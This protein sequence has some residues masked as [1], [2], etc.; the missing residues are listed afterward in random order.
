MAVKETTLS[1][2]SA[3]TA[4]AATTP[5]APAAKA[6]AIKMKDDVATFKSRPAV[7]PKEE[8]GLVAKAVDSAKD[9]AGEAKEF[10][11]DAVCELS[12]VVKSAWE[13]FAFWRTMS[14][15]KD[16]QAEQE[17]EENKKKEK[18]SY[19]ARVESNGLK[20]KAE[21][22]ADFARGQSKAQAA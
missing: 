13:T 15:L 9:L 1:R 19:A 20:R 11:N 16:Y 17:K 22:D 6:P 5:V 7:A 3:T 8:P 2:P 14:A 4:P 10:A 12:E 21:A 18:A